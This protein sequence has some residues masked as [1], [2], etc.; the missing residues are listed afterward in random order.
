MPSLNSCVIRLVRLSAI[1]TA[2]ILTVSLLVSSLTFA[3]SIKVDGSLGPRTTLTGPNYAI[4][5]DLGQTRGANL[6][7][8]FEQFNIL[9]GE[10]ATFTGPNTIS[11]VISRVTGG[12][13]SFI[14][15]LLGTEFAGAKPE[16]YLINPNGLLF[17]PNASLNVSGAVHFSTA[18]YLRFTDQTGQTGLFA[19]LSETTTLS[20]GPV[21]AFGFLGATTQGIAI[22]ESML[23]VST[24]TTLSLIGGDISITGGPAGFQ[25]APSGLIQL[26]S[27]KSTGEVPANVSSFNVTQAGPLGD[28]V[29]AE[30]TLIDVAGDGGGTVV[31]RGGKLTLDNAYIFAD[32]LGA[33]QGRAIA[34]D[35]DLATQLLLTNGA[36]ITA[37]VVAAG[38]GGDILIRAGS[39][40]VGPDSILAARSFGDGRAG[41]ISVEAETMNLPGGRITTLTGGAGDAGDITLDLTRLTLTE[42][43]QLSVT[44]LAGSTGQ[45]GRLSIFADGSITISGEDPSGNASGLFANT[46][47]RGTG[48]VMTVTTP[49]LTMSGGQLQAIA[50]SSGNGGD[51]VLN[52]GSAAFMGSTIQAEAWNTGNAGSVAITSQTVNLTAGTLISI[53]STAGSTGRAGSL[54]ITADDAVFIGG[55]DSTG[56]ISGISANT[57][58]LGTGGT[59]QIAAPDIVFQDARVQAGTSGPG[60]GGAIQLNASRIDLLDGG[61]VSTTAR[62]G[63]SGNAGSITAVATEAITIE[64]R[65]SD[66]L[67]SGFFAIAQGTGLGGSITLSSSSLTV[68]NARISTSTFGPNAGGAV[69]IDIRQLMLRNDGEIISQSENTATGTGGAI[70]ITASEGVHIVGNDAPRQS[71]IFVSSL[72]SGQS[73]T[74]ILQ[75]PSVILEGGALLA[76]AFGQ[77]D[78]GRVQLDV[79]DLNILAA[80]QINTSTVANGKAGDV[81]IVAAGN[82]TI[83]ETVR[84]SPQQIAPSTIQSQSFSQGKAGNVFLTAHSVALLEGGRIDASA[85]GA[86]A[87][88]TITVNA[89]DAINLS[90][91]GNGLQTSI[92]TT[93]N[94]SGFGGNISLMAGT[95]ITVS[96]Q[97][98]ITAKSAGTGNAGNITLTAGDTIRL[99]DS[100]V[101]S[102]AS[103]ASG[104]N[105]KFTAPNLIQII[106]GQIVTLVQGGAQTVGGNINIDPQ[107]VVLQNSQILAT[108]TQGNGGNITI[109]GNVV[110]V[111][112]GSVIDASSALGVSGQVAIQAPVNNVATA[113]SR[114]S[115]TP[116]NAA[117]LLTARC[118]ARLRE[119]LTSS[120]TLAGRDGV[121]AEPGSWRPTAFL[122]AGLRPTTA[123][124]I[125]ARS[126]SSIRPPLLLQSPR[127]EFYALRDAAPLP[128][129]CGS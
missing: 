18:D 37:D 84:F 115:Q 17:G 55:R 113:L 12:V 91:Q 32:T 74:L 86:G 80:G 44:T 72:G 6:F 118:S 29:L 78:G 26:A 11:R 128:L 106:N 47:G 23:Q 103:V 75:S 69:L 58:G 122:T 34:V 88:G 3:Q 116:L 125:A 15:G 82:V 104:G 41:N 120:L 43:A 87:G 76:V 5:H 126:A 98:L 101:T 89:A 64:G 28:I 85:L 8:S 46:Q 107:F 60:D 20:A 25:S 71:G 92:A 68:S 63:S 39:A 4:P 94:D 77:G 48:G 51:I 109:A 112:P 100:S 81:H 27:M 127:S 65:G 14:D 33:E 99:V 38:K 9:T 102:A 31:I 111:D 7:H 123:P 50:T 1:S 62:A 90:G 97:A 40:E 45:G 13:Q 79:G 24:G 96:D 117:E 16:L 57:R 61:Q 49:D 30:G 119:G 21:A 42:G 114:L 95:S 73:G 110:M 19:K 129:G 121:P 108:A 66:Q 83:Q 22:Q 105:V 52:V 93:S 56:F 10:S 54:T 59:I 2:V 70:T 67:P 53:D 36:A 35:A 124:T